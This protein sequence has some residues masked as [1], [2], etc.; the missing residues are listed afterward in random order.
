[1]G[2]AMTKTPHPGESMR[3]SLNDLL[4]QLVL[5]GWAKLDL[6]AGVPKVTP[7]CPWWSIDLGPVT[8]VSLHPWSNGL[9]E[10]S[11]CVLIDAEEQIQ[12]Y[13]LEC[14]AMPVPVALINWWGGLEIALEQSEALKNQL[15]AAWDQ[16]ISAGGELP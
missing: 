6:P 3:S 11:I 16:E 7:D 8:T 4:E 13:E 10:F 14:N 12:S 9:L 5:R 15:I 2:R 1:M